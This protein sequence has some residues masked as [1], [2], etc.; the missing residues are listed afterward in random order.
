MVKPLCWH[1]FW[2][3]DFLGLSLRIYL[4]VATEVKKHGKS[5]SYIY[6]FCY[7]IIRINNL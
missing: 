4:L 7:D 1:G 5:V 2:D 6:I 3:L